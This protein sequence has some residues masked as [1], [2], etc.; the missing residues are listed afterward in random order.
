MVFRN[1]PSI[2]SIF[3]CRNRNNR[4]RHSTWKCYV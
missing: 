2:C 3:Y 1:Y 4:C